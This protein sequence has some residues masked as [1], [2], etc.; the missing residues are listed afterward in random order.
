MT[1]ENTKFS[2]SE[3]FP[4]ITPIFNNNAPSLSDSR[5][6]IV[7]GDVLE[8]M[9]RMETGSIDVVVTSPPYNIGVRYRNYNDRRPR[10][11]YLAW[12]NEIAEPIARVLKDDGAAFINV[13]VGPDPWI[14]ADV[15][16]KFRQYF[17]LQNRISWVKSISI[18]DQT[19]GHFKPINSQRFLNRA[20]EEIYHFTKNGA[21]PIDRLAIGVPYQHKGNIGRWAHAAS[22]MR[23]GG[24]VWFIP[25]ETMT[26]TAKKYHH[27]AIFPVELPRRCLRIHGG[28][29]TVLDPFVGTGTTLVAAKMLGWHGVGIEIDDVYVDTARARLA[30]M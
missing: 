23:C 15:A 19:R 11:E 4:F 17:T 13:G 9:S 20:H 1:I 28:C 6:N 26:T 3:R 30:E 29:G 7:L 5:Q 14:A 27:P 2:Q 18:D 21:V 12:M 8:V 22:D 25:Y 10:R 24:N 16:G